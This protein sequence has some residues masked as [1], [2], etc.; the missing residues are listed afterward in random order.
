MSGLYARVANQVNRLNRWSWGNYWGKPH[1]PTQ[2]IV[3]WLILL[4]AILVIVLSDG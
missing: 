1:S 2:V 3:L 4:G